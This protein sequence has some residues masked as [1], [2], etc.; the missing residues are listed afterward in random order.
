LNT[1]SQLPGK[2]KYK[3]MVVIG[4]LLLVVFDNSTN[5]LFGD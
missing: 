2:L 3:P 5:V 4:C 1:S